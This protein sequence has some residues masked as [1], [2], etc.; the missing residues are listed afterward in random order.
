MSLI[1][2]Y[3]I[4]SLSNVKQGNS[5]EENEQL[6]LQDHYYVNF[7]NNY[8]FDSTGIQISNCYVKY[9]KLNRFNHSAGSGKPFLTDFSTI[10]E[11]YS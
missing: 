5:K 8:N 10:S 3:T 6:I 4:L 11:A 9:F 7:L 1:T 2:E